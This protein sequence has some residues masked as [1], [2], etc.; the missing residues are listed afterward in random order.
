MEQDV[1]LVTGDG[2]GCPGFFRLAFC[3]PENTVERSLT[4]L[5]KILQHKQ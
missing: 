1:M 2:F 3:V 5:K 4:A